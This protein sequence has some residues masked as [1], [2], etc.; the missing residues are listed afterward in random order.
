MRSRS[1]I[2][3]I[4]KT[5]IEVRPDTRVASHRRTSV[6]GVASETGRR[7]SARISVSINPFSANTSGTRDFGKPERMD[8]L[9]QIGLFMPRCDVC[10]AR[11]AS[12]KC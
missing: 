10:C 9:Q 2:R 12:A 11:A 6:T 4:S 5:S 1:S 7:M 3:S 8:L